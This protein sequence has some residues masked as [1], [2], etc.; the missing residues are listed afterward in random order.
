MYLCVYGMVD[1]F[2]RISVY[3]CRE[4]SIFDIMYTFS[5]KGTYGKDRAKQSK[6]CNG[7][8][9]HVCIFVGQ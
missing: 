6:D 1:C 7:T 9:R 4:S 5:S 3:V 8:N 2:D